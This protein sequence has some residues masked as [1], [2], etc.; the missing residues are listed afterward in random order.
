MSKTIIEDQLIENDI[1][2]LE[3]K[4]KIANS[5][6][7]FYLNELPSFP[8]CKN[9]ND[10]IEYALWVYGYISKKNKNVSL[11][12]PVSKNI[13]ENISDMSN[14]LDFKFFLEA[15]IF[16]QISKSPLVF[17]ESIMPFSIN[18]KCQCE[19]P[20]IKTLRLPIG[21][22]FLVEYLYMNLQ[23]F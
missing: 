8:L 5:I 15:E 22:E 12:F 9:K 7:M 1:A 2:F 13:E 20:Q 11:T 3:K 4:L 10:L 17:S 14:I 23:N 19:L 6:N 18:N 16:F 21:F